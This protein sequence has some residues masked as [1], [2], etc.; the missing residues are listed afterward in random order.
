MWVCI[1]RIEED[2][3]SC[4]SSSLISVFGMVCFGDYIV[5]FIDG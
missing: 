2:V 1:G 3:L 4:M 5:D